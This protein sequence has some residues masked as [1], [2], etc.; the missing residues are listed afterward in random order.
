MHI[1]E[2]NTNSE[3]LITN[4]L[5]ASSKSE[6]NRQTG[7]YLIGGLLL[8]D[9]LIVWISMSIGFWLKF[10]GVL[11]SVG[12]PVSGS[13]SYLSY[14]PQFILANALLLGMQFYTH[15]YSKAGLVASPFIAVKSSFLWGILLSFTSLLLKVDPAISRIFIFCSTIFLMLLLPLWRQSYKRLIQHHYTHIVQRSTVLVG[16]SERAEE[17]LRRSTQDRGFFPMRIVAVAGAPGSVNLPDTIQRI[18]M[19]NVQLNEFLRVHSSDQLVIAGDSIDSATKH[20][21]QRICAREMVEYVIIPDKLDAL[22]GCLHIESVQGM[23]LLT[24]TK[25]P[26]DRLENSLLKRF[27]DI[28]GALFGI[29]VFTPIIAIFCLLVYRESP[30]P[31]FYRQTRVGRNGTPFKIIKIRSM[32]NDAEASTGALWCTED[33]PRRLHVGAFMR[34]MNIDELPQFWNVLIGHMSLV[35][36]RPERPELINNFKNEIDFYNLR[37][38]VKPGI[39]GWAQVNGWRGDTC[40]KSRIACDLEYIER[41][42]LW[43]DIHILLK[44]FRSFKNAY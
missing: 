12:L 33:D 11:R 28:C 20:Y 22:T 24:Q 29:L 42:G 35:G 5:D 41:A 38:T 40:L 43:F 8:G 18:P 36:P 23:P 26:L 15:R 13:V 4:A 16:W 34:R 3:A 1:E 25:R 32:R 6:R 17:L 9:S 21:L 44:T 30:G 7:L 37:H 39:T 2:P 31:V 14:M 10:E 27:V 19:G